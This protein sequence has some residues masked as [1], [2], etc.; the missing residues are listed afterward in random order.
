[1]NSTLQLQPAVS[2]VAFPELTIDEI[3]AR[4]AAIGCLGVELRTF[5]PGSRGLASDPSLIAPEK[6]RALADRH[7]VQ[8]VSLGTSCRFDEPVWPPVIGYAISD[9]EKSIRDAK[10]HIDLATTLEC[11][12]V[13]VFAF[14]PPPRESTKSAT[15][16]IASRLR[17]VVAHAHRTGVRVSIENGGRYATAAQ[18]M[19]IVDAVGSPLLGVSYNVAVAAAAGEPPSSGLNVLGDKLLSLRLKD[20]RA[21]EPCP[22]GHGESPVQDAVRRAAESDLVGRIPVIIEWDRAWRTD[23]AAADSV[24]PEA[25]KS[26]FG[27]MARP[28]AIPQA[29][30]AR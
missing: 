24:L 18:I 1:M 4:A 12:L 11:P 13:R 28:A 19:A 26:V 3:F 21:G 8:V 5:G 9:T 20:H 22:L 16:R 2:S 23:L 25:V 15:A 17:L 10:R 30:A 27:W 14:D 29:A 6:I 7:G